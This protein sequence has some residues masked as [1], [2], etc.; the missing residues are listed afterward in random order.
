MDL[1]HDLGAE[2]RV[3]CSDHDGILQG[4]RE[5]TGRNRLTPGL[6]DHDGKAGSALR[7]HSQ[8]QERKPVAD[9]RVRECLRCGEDCPQGNLGIEHDIPRTDPCHL[10]KLVGPEMALHI[11]PI[12]LQ[13]GHDLFNIFFGFLQRG[14][15]YFFHNLI[16]FP[17]KPFMV[18]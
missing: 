14:K 11:E 6:Q 4:G 9:I 1:G 3:V 12:P 15:P 13:G 18:Q 8:R 16:L 10:F 17:A 7:L 2:G 5:R